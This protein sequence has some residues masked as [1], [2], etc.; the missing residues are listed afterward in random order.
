MRGVLEMCFYLKVI[1]YKSSTTPCDAHP[2][3]NVTQFCY[4]CERGICILCRYKPT[5]KGHQVEEAESVANAMKIRIRQMKDQLG[6]QTQQIEKY[7]S[8]KDQIDAAA[9]KELHNL[10]GRQTSIM[11][12]MEQFV[13]NFDRKITHLQSKL[14][15]QLRDMMPIDS[16]KHVDVQKGVTLAE[17]LEKLSDVELLSKWNHGYLELSSFY[18]EENFDDLSL[19]IE[20]NHVS[21]NLHGGLSLDVGKHPQI[22]GQLM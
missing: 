14:H 11:K 10:R 8:L 2:D 7:Q 4:H 6:K 9:E 5:H 22:L 13:I 1:P 19:Q 12:E 21:E 18:I 17:E 15:A 16:N 3:R 20:F